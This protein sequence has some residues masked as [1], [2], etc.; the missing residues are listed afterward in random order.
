M[1]VSSIHPKET[2]VGSQREWWGVFQRTV[3]VCD[4]IFRAA[5]ETWSL[6]AKWNPMRRLGTR[7]AVI[8][9]RYPAKDIDA[10]HESSGI[11]GP[12]GAL[13]SM[14]VSAV[15]IVAS[16]LPYHHRRFSCIALIFGLAV[17][18]V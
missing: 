2:A 9:G 12:S 7:W 3:A 4:R 15:G 14:T 5:S 18:T 1:V 10:C 8:E 17:S 11:Q 13:I 6:S 16:H